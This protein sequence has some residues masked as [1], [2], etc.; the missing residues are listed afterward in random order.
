ML[1]YFFAIYGK[2]QQS[3]NLQSAPGRRSG[4]QSTVFRQS[5]DCGP[6]TADYGVYPQC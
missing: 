1:L 4:S 5:K 6:E 2:I 3:D